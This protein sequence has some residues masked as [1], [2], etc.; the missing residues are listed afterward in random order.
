MQTA[1]IFNILFEDEYLVAIDK[2]SGIMVHRTR[3]SEDTRFVLQL[4]RDQLGRRLYPVHR[5]DRGTSGVLVFGK[6]REAAA[7]L[8]GQFRDK[9]VGKKYLAIIR[10]YVEEEGTIDYPIARDTTRPRQEAVTHY[11]R[12]GQSEI[13]YPV[14]RYTTARYSLV[15]ARPVT[16]RHHQVRRHFAHIRHPVIGDKKHGDVKHNKF[17]REQWGIS[18]LLLHASSLAFVHP[19]SGEKV[20]ITAPL[21]DIFRTALGRLRLPAPL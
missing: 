10:G 6:T 20:S 11:T 19:V 9:G 2:P 14:G 7:L 4:F 8:S 12:L 5:L 18:R 13:A 16:G 1:D 17:M 21:D 15:E 3:I